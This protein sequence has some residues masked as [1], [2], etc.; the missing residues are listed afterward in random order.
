M[1]KRLICCTALIAGSLQQRRSV[2]AF[3]KHKMS[4]VLAQPDLQS[5][6]YHLSAEKEKYARRLGGVESTVVSRS[7]FIMGC[8]LGS[9]GCMKPPVA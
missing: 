2:V 7:D 8:K 6:Y 5:W 1:P 4:L 3:V 9:Y